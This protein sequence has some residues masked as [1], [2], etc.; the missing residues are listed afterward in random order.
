[1]NLMGNGDDDF[2]LKWENRDYGKLITDGTH[3]ME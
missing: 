3:L 2:M 1:M